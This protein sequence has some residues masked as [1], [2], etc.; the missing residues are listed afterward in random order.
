[1]ARKKTTS[2]LFA[3]KILRKEDMIRKN[4]VNNVLAER[5][6][7]AL[8]Q[9]PF[10]VKLFFAFQSQNFLYLVIEI[11]HEFITLK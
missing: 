3:I 11:I 4:M 7:L 8:A 6:V 5:N 9:A 1:L 10:I 2:D